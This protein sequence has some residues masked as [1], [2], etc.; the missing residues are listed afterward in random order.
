[1][2][3]LIEFIKNEIDSIKICK[4][5]YMNA[6]TDPE[7]SFTMICDPPHVLVWAKYKDY[8]YWPSKVMNTTDKM[9]NVRFFADHMGKY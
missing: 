6:S 3:K 5:C 4:Q 9:V 7:H 8:C 2:G 1:M